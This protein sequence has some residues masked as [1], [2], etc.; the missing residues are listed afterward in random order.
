M[1]KIK[2]KSG[3]MFMNETYTS[4]SNRMKHPYTVYEV[5]EIIEECV[6]RARDSKGHGVESALDDLII[7]VEDLY[8]HK[9]QQLKLI[10]Q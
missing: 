7:L 10:K 4:T 5:A 1:P 6:D 3:T 8:E 2:T 9:A